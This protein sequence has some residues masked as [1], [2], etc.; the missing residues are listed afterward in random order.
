M[1]KE[2]LPLLDT[3]K[4]RFD[5]EMKDEHV[6][7]YIIP[8]LLEGKKVDDSDKP[9]LEQPLF[10]KYPVDTFTNQELVDDI[11][12]Y[13]NVLVEGTNTI[14]EIEKQIKARADEK[15]KPSKRATNGKKE[16]VAQKKKREMEEAREKQAKERA[17]QA[18]LPLD[19]G[20]RLGEKEEEK[21]KEEKPTITPPPTAEA[22]AESIATAVDNKQDDDPLGLGLGDLDL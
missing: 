15:K 4:L 1:I 10:K 14:L 22:E 7:V 19:D 12:A 2:I 20:N 11:H 13:T 6:W 17:N 18:D 5:V 3:H 21:P 16:T 8:A 9:V